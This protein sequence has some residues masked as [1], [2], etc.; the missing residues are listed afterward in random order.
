M[1]AIVEHEGNILLCR[2]GIEPQRGLWTVPAGA[3]AEMLARGAVT[4][5]RRVLPGTP[6]TIPS[7]TSLLSLTHPSPPLITYG[8]LPGV[9]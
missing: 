5:R 2:R 1:G 6:T 7:L 8:R 4:S 9:R 3:P